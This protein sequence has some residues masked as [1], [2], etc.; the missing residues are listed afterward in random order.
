MFHPKYHSLSNRAYGMG[1]TIGKHR[2]ADWFMVAI[3][4]AVEENREFVVIDVPRDVFRSVP[5]R[6]AVA[7]WSFGYS[8]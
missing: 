2:L 4:I 5:A 7:L 1:S 8:R 6:F 3:A